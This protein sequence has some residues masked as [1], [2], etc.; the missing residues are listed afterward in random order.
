MRFLF[1]GNK[2]FLR[3]DSLCLFWTRFGVDYF[4]CFKGVV[5]ACGISVL[6]NLMRLYHFTQ[7]C[8]WVC[9]VEFQR[10]QQNIAFRR[11]H[12]F[13]IY[14]NL[15]AIDYFY[16]KPV[17]LSNIWWTPISLIRR[18]GVFFFAVIIFSALR[19]HE[20]DDIQQRLP[21]SGSPLRRKWRS[22]GQFWCLVMVLSLVGPRVSSL[23]VLEFCLRAVSAWASAGLVSS[24]TIQLSRQSVQSQFQVWLIPCSLCLATG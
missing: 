17:N 19:D 7:R 21:L 12:T 9:S 2:T 13:K 15:Q 1:N 20:N 4:V 10:G 5:G 6:C 8:R 18:G 24:P 11:K 14:L 3:G 16:M 22:A 23:I